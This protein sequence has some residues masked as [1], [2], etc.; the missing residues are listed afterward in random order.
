MFTFG[1]AEVGRYARVRSGGS[2]PLIHSSADRLM[3][4]LAEFYGELLRR[5]GV[6][7]GEMTA[8]WPDALSTSIGQEIRAAYLARSS[9][10]H[11]VNRDRHWNLD[12]GCYERVPDK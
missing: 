12:S 6:P 9:D 7:A 8:P 1:P 10:E 4:T 2:V 5:E 3:T 11:F